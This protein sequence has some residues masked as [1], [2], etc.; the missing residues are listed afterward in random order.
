MKLLRFVI[1]ILVFLAPLTTSA[2][3]DLS[4]LSA[5]GLA[6]YGWKNGVPTVL[7][8]E[9]DGYL[10]PVAS[11]T[12]LI[13]AKAAVSLYP[14]TST[15]TISKES[16][17]NAFENDSLIVPGMVF[18]RD[19]MLRALLINSNNAVANQFVLSTPGTLFVDTMNKFLHTKD[20]TTTS[21]TNP[22]GLDSYDKTVLPNRLTPKKISYLLSDIY[23]EDPFLTAIMKEKTSV[24]TNKVTGVQVPVKFPFTWATVAEPFRSVKSG[25]ALEMTPFT[26]WVMNWVATDA[27][28]NTVVLM[29]PASSL[30]ESF[31]VVEST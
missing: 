20:Y 3:V 6:I 21:F 30:I 12:K 2:A 10:F 1:F 5:K 7:Y 13:T 17:I 19:D 8:S 28:L 26:I 22:S 24:V 31:L 15:F 25:C 9:K 11:I 23:R 16:M 14:A 18:T 4:K 29:K 27:E